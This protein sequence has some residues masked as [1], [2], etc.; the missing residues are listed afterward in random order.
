[1]MGDSKWKA[2]PMK[3]EH[4]Y[5]AFHLSSFGPLPLWPEGGWSLYQI[6]GAQIAERTRWERRDG[7]HVITE[8]WPWPGYIG[9]YAK[10]D[11]ALAE[12]RKLAEV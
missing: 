3:T 2:N 12:I 9:I 7:E 4:D 5:L 6:T 11:E 8:R 10:L 1:M